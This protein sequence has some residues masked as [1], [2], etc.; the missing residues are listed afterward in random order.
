LNK[1]LKDHKINP[2]ENKE[3]VDALLDWKKKI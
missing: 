3:F 1:L 2:D